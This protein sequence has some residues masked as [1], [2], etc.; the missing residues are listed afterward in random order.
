MILTIYIKDNCETCLSLIQK[1]DGLK[2]SDYGFNYEAIN[3]SNNP[4][5]KTSVVPAL[6]CGNEILAFGEADILNKI[7]MALFTNV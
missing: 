7:R 5:A 3:V 2:L 1:L 6:F 4:F